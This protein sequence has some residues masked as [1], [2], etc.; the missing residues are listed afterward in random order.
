MLSSQF[1]TYNI[2]GGLT[3]FYVSNKILY[4]YIYC[5]IMQV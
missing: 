4:Y 5:A 1:T 3:Y 2:S